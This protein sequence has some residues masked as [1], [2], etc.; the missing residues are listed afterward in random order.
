MPPA[1]FPK[2]HT[3]TVNTDNIEKIRESVRAMDPKTD[4]QRR[5][6]IATLELHITQERQRRNR[7]SLI[8]VMRQKQERLK[9]MK[10]IPQPY[11]PSK[12]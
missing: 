9:R 4:R 10:M 11:K 8:A 6:F 5:L 2:T 12:V 7:R 3:M 1:L